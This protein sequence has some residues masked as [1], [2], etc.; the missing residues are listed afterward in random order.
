MARVFIDGFEAGNM[1][2]WTSN[3]GCS[4]I[5]SGALD[6]NYSVYMT[7]NPS[8]NPNFMEKYLP[9]AQE[10]HI[11]F[12]MIDNLH[13]GNNLLS[14]RS[15]STEIVSLKIETVEPNARFYV[16]RNTVLAY[17]TITNVMGNIARIAFRV[18]VNGAISVIQV[19]IDGVLDI[20]LPTVDLGSH[21]SMDNF[22]LITDYVSDGNGSRT[23]DNIIVD[24]SEFP[25]GT[26]IQAIVPTG[27]G[28]IE[29]FNPNTTYTYWRLNITSNNGA[30]NLSIDEIELRDNA[31]GEDICISGTSAG[32]GGVPS[33]AFNNTAALWTVNAATGWIY[34]RFDGY[35]NIVQYKIK[36]RG[37]GFEA[38]APK[39]WSFE[40]SFDGVTWDVIVSEGN[41][42]SWV[43]GETRAFSC[44]A[45]S[46]GFNWTC[47]D[48]IPNSDSDYVSSGT[49]G[50]SDLYNASNLTGSVSSIKC[51]QVQARAWKEGTNPPPAIQ[52]AV[53]TNGE[54]KYSSANVLTNSPTAVS[55]VWQLNPS[56]SGTNTWTPAE[57]NSIEIGVTT[58]S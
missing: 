51:V 34:Y 48:E 56:G 19:M 4:L 7:R 23:F 6:G 55:K 12:L 46:D 47:V 11:G 20:N 15:G 10:Y 50:T 38:E 14:I 44:G 1:G 43:A 22:R 57:V 52:L 13:R 41:Q 37:D 3:Y 39:S 8:S 42:I 30:S 31:L 45:S 33:N 24:T 35:V 26:K 32:S 54:T 18:K 28:T 16:F 9:Q 58:S 2:L 5:T 21:L 53:R 36:V 49:I 29:Q 40:R 17:S 25:I 27:V